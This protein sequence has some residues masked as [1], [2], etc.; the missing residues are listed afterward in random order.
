MTVTNTIDVAVANFT[1]GAELE[2]VSRVAHTACGHLLG[3]WQLRVLATTQ[4]DRW[5]MR[6]RGAF[7]RHVAHFVAAPCDLPEHV[8]RGLRVFLRD[9]VPPLST[10][11]RSTSDRRHP[12]ALPGSSRS[13]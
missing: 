3:H 13:A 12:P 11:S 10:V 2:G 5:V 8:E 9:I 4:S 6:L 7:G 1:T